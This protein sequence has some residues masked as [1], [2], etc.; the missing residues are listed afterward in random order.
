MRQKKR[1]DI[2]ALDQVILG[3]EPPVPAD[4]DRA[5]M[6]HAL[7]WYRC[8]WEPAQIK[9][10]VCKRL[11]KLGLDD[12]VIVLSE[13]KDTEIPPTLAANLRIEQRGGTVNLQWRQQ[14]LDQ[15]FELGFND[16]IKD[17][18]SPSQRSQLSIGRQIIGLIDKKIEDNQPIDCYNIL[19]SQQISKNQATIVFEHFKIINDNIVNFPKE[20]A[21]N[22]RSLT[23]IQRKAFADTIKSIVDDCSRF[24]SNANKQR[25]VRKKP[26]KKANVIKASYC[27]EFDPLKIVSVDINKVVGSSQIIV[28][29]H[30]TRVISVIVGLSDDKLKINRSSLANIDDN[31]SYSKK[32]RKPESFFADWHKQSKSQHFKCVEKLASKKQKISS[33]LNDKIVILEVK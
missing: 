2:K 6:A 22:Y 17:A 31:V 4:H 7:Y 14:K 13:L 18:N 23:R 3:S 25:I 32:I 19:T 9:D 15:L 16:Q 12:F 1:Q 27:K 28:Y 21:E 11:S 26:S 20:F 29:N 30:S 10:Y 24:I 5:A 8:M 33:R